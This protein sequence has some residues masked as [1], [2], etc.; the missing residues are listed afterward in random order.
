MD[1]AIPQPHPRRFFIVAEK[2][3][4]RSRVA[5]DAPGASSE[6]NARAAE[7]SNDFGRQTVSHAFCLR[8][9]IDT[10]FPAALPSQ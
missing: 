10:T 4:Q 6:I 1:D 2:A 8:P 7:A 5:I 3:A 9:F